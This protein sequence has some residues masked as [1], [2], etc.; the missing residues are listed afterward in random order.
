MVL[1]N[2]E[3][4][5]KYTKTPGERNAIDEI[6]S[7]ILFTQRILGTQILEPSWS[8]KKYSKYIVFY[9]LSTVYLTLGTLNFLKDNLDFTTIIEVILNLSVFVAFPTKV[10]IFISQRSSFLTCY[11]INKTTFLDLIKELAPEKVDRIKKLLRLFVKIQFICV[12]IPIGSFVSIALWHNLNGSRVT[13]SRTTST[14]LPM[15]TPYFEICFI[16]QFIFL[17]S[18][19]FNIIVVDFWFVFLIFI[20]CE[21]CDCTVSVLEVQKAGVAPYDIRLNDALRK[22]YKIHVTLTE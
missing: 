15:T 21:V 13:L 3:I 9:F 16:F 11:V 1:T 4:I 5:R 6:V 22:F 8:W 7:P 10:S 17:N 20:Y 2:K 18:S 14:L 19:A 12:I